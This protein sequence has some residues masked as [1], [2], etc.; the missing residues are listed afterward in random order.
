VRV[1]KRHVM[2]IDPVVL[3]VPSP[4]ANAVS[5]SVLTRPYAV[6]VAGDPYDQMSWGA[7]RHPFRPV[8]RRL[9][10]HKQR[11]LCAHATSINY[12]TERS[13]QVRYP[14]SRTAES[15]SGSDVDLPTDA[16]YSVPKRFP[17]DRL[18]LVC[19]GM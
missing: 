7:M 12:V 9:Y 16:Y 2:C 15:F 19:V 18:R 10:V 1:L 17:G 11:K 3:R 6:E 14:P 5:D 4:L 8:F 13:L